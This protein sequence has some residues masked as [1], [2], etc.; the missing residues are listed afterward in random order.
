MIIAPSKLSYLITYHHI[1]SR[2]TLEISIKNVACLYWW[3]HG[4]SSAATVQGFCQ[5]PDGRSES[6]HTETYIK[7]PTATALWSRQTGLIPDLV[8][9][10]GLCHTALWSR[11]TGLFYTQGC[12]TQPIIVGRQC[13]PSLWRYYLLAVCQG[14]GHCRPTRYA[15]HL[16]AVGRRQYTR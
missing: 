8:I 10:S 16:A 1:S 11:Q 2:G 6:W 7:C 14:C 9:L 13:Q 4:Y 12:A 5:T 3:Q 15:I